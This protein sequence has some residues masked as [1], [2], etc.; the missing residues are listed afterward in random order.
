MSPAAASRLFTRAAFVG[1]VVWVAL[2]FVP[3]PSALDGDLG[4]PLALA[5]HLL[6][7]APL[8]LVPLY[9]DAAVPFTLDGRVDGALA[10]AARLIV[11]GSLAAA[12]SVLVPT[13]AFAGGV[14]A[15]WL[16]PTLAVAVWGVRHVLRQRQAR[17]LMA[18][19]AAIGAGLVV[20]PVGAVALVLARWGVDPEP[21]GP[22]VMLLTAVHL[23]YAGFVAPLWAGLLGRALAGARP[24]GLAVYRP[25]AL[26]LVVG[27]LLV[28]LEIGL[29]RSPGG[30]TLMETVGVIVWATGAIGLGV[31]GLLTAPRLESRGGSLMV[32]V[33]AGALILG[34]GLALWFTLGPRLEGEAVDVAW[35]LPRHGWLNAIGLGLWGALGWRQLRPRPALGR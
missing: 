10:V 21:Y 11:P 13:G 32:A 31:L 20:L 9:V 7:L 26:A 35:V 1:L 27:A 5:T 34:M 22:L 33:S 4:G 23:H 30:G 12:A 25:L 29:G 28:A 14:A 17:A 19:E 8:V 15:V 2:L 3:L 6:L 16:L 18:P 24:G